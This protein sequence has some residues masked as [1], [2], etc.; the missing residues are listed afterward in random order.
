MILCTH[1]LFSD[2]GYVVLPR[3][4]SF[5]SDGASAYELASCSLRGFVRIITRVNEFCHLVDPDLQQSAMSESVTDF[6]NDFLT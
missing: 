5:F 3:V 4:L 1:I 2:F 6:P